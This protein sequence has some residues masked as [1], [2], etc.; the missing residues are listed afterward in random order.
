LRAVTVG[1]GKFT[2]AQE[3]FDDLDFVGTLV[4]RVASVLRDLGYDVTEVGSYDLTGERLAGEIDAVFQSVGSDD[5]LVVHVVGHGVVGDG[6]LYVAGSDGTP[7]PGLDVAHWLVTLQN[8]PDRPRT[9]FLLDLCFS[10]AAA[11]LPWQ[12][13]VPAETARGWV[14]AACQ[15]GGAAYDGRFTEALVNVLRDLNDSTFDIDPTAEHVPL[16]TIAR[17]IRRE[18]NRLAEAA[19]SFSQTVTASL[20]DLSSALELPFFPNRDHGTDPRAGMRMALNP[21]LLPFLDELDEGLD[22]RHFLDRASGVGLR[23][24]ALIG[25]F[26]GRREQLQ[27]LVP[28]INGQSDAALAVVTGSPGVGKSALIGI[29][30]CAAH[31]ELR[32]ATR[33]VWSE[34]DLAPYPV[35]ALAAVHAR[36]RSVDAIA[37][38]V[39]VQ[40]VLPDSTHTRDLP[41]LLVKHFPPPVIVV[42]AL[43]E[44]DDP[45][46]VVEELLLPLAR[47]R[48]DDG[49]PAVR[50]LVGLRPYDELSPL[51]DE[52]ERSGLVVD[53]NKVTS[54]V[55]ENDLYRYVSDLARTDPAF[56]RA[57][58]ATGAF[59]AEVA[60]RLSAPGDASAEWGAFLVAGLYTRHLM[61]LHPR[62]EGLDATTATDLGRAIPQ[63]LPSVLELELGDRDQHSLRPV[64]AAVA[65]ARGDGMPLSVI[66]RVADRFATAP[67]ASG[68]VREALAYAKFYLRQSTD[69]DRTTVYRLF[70][71][72]LT[73]HLVATPVR[74]GQNTPPD[75]AVLDAMLAPLGHRD[76][77]D[78]DAA[79]PYVVRNALAEAAQA[80]RLTH[81]LFDYTFLLLAETPALL[82]EQFP[83][84]NL[85]VDVVHDFHDT[86]LP[87]TR[88]AFALFAVRAGWGT[89]TPKTI[90]SPQWA[91]SDL[92]SSQKRQPVSTTLVV[93]NPPGVASPA[94]RIVM[95]ANGKTAAFVDQ[96]GIVV[97]WSD[98]GEE[99][100]GP[101]SRWPLSMAVN[102]DATALVIGCLRETPEVYDLENLITTVDGRSAP[103]TAVVVSINP[104]GTRSAWIDP[105][106]ELHLASNPANYE[107]LTMNTEQ[108]VLVADIA[109]PAPDFAVAVVAVDDGLVFWDTAE[110]GVNGKIQ[111][112]APITHISVS[113]DAHT[114]AYL[115]CNGD[116]TVFHRGK[117]TAT[118]PSS[119]GRHRT[120]IALNSNGDRLVVGNESGLV[121]CFDARSG[122]ALDAM[123]AH[124]ARIAHVA[125]DNDAGVVL[126]SALDGSVR[127]WRR[128]VDKPPL[129][130]FGV[131]QSTDSMV[132][133]VFVGHVDKPVTLRDTRVARGEV[134]VLL[135]GDLAGV[136][137]RIDLKSG[138]YLRH[139][140]R[141]GNAITQISEFAISD[142]RLLGIFDKSGELLAWDAN[143][144]DT[145]PGSHWAGF[146]DARQA[147]AATRTTDYK[148]ELV[149]VVPM[150]DGSVLLR[151]V[152][153]QAPVV[154][155][156]GR[157]D[158]A[159]TVVRVGMLDERPVVVSG[160]DDGTVRIWAL[161]GD[162]IGEPEVIPVFAPVF[163]VAIA[164]S[165]TVLVG[166]G[167]ELIAF[168]RS[169]GVR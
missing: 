121:E 95:S 60:Q 44:A 126:S 37:R 89:L 138:K 124:M 18:T 109:W 73:D 132:S 155:L 61:H 142:R 24:D 148:G 14:I 143:S 3:R 78:W 166:A 90:W 17:A 2:G 156:P 5:V 54:E 28:W 108:V 131:T 128:N 63:D 40:L 71:Q 8:L 100:P 144:G 25:C 29:L 72:G 76:E 7:H 159:V 47:A 81:I 41:A 116:A 122:A 112:D 163:D 70:H 53:L 4:P 83:D 21:H 114:V 134:D 115:D 107:F 86:D 15:P 160:G 123:R 146:P 110:Q 101:T 147:N 102:A 1:V 118:I 145:T 85:F 12:A 57:G 135:A 6:A 130:A 16:T 49:R 43:D 165:G 157:H 125:I 88:E 168:V 119:E 77:R 67:L 13:S 104:A 34:V 59:A 68:E 91:R 55:L 26:R 164:V 153:T 58:A 19:D 161:D 97:L 152:W 105:G 120:C 75:D 39:A 133:Q 149:E 140:G 154:I 10:G 45:Q 23:T 52:A 96:D 33:P 48:R 42:D 99:R 20:V 106:G 137:A 66:A 93:S 92:S 79:E 56:R 98:S 127:L 167:G 139:V 129:T 74:P 27:Q 51:T 36:Q 82:E 113:T 69:A 94:P 162:G 50:L 9:L 151:G 32:A 169:R 136:C 35:S 150:D 64:L 22:A 158:G 30:V 62:A 103:T 141:H 65:R 80:D 38:S 31:K 46:R 111:H 117:V 87:R 84:R 11:R